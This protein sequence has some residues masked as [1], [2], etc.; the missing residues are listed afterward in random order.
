M[1]EILFVPGLNCTGRLFA[2]QI[3]AL[4]TEHR[5]HVA[6]H[7]V[8][9]SLEAIAASVLEAAPSHFALVGLSMGGYVALEIMRQS[10]ERVSALALLDTRAQPDSEEE[11]ERRRQTIALARAGRFESLHAP[12]WQRLVHSDR[13]RDAPL[14]AIVTGMMR[15]TGPERFIRQQTAI[16][17]RRDYRPFL[18][19]IRAPTLVLV[20][21][22][23]VITP[24]DQVRALHLAI[25]G[26]RYIEVPDCGH[27]SSLERPEAVTKALVEL[28]AAM[29]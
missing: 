25:A 21:K 3:E 14:E 1:T 24:P 4:A 13:L 17:N 18:S 9:D 20:G 28:V 23:D 19:G 8:A 5:C 11:A 15:D 27:L 29:R 12:L 26:S 2:H 7:G 6:D 22:Q 10:P 16:L